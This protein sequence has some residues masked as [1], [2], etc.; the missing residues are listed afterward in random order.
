MPKKTVAPGAATLKVG[1]GKHKI[2][3]ETDKRKNKH[4]SANK[5]A[6][7][8]ELKL[9]YNSLFILTIAH[10]SALKKQVRIYYCLPTFF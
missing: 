4:I 6:V 5:K 8:V 7:A 9:N 3:T 10:A 1:G 2:F